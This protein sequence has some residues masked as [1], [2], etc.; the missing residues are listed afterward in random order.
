[1]RS[2]KPP[3][4]AAWLLEYLTPGDKHD[5]LVGDLLEE[6]QHRCSAAW[7]WRQVLHA[8][9]A[10]LFHEMCAHSVVRSVEFGLTWV[11]VDFV[12]F[13]LLPYLRAQLWVMAFEPHVR[14]LWR[15]VLN[16]VTDHFYPG[17]PWS[18]FARGVSLGT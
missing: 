3:T 18:G 9:P 2:S 7:F 8:I 14:I 17:E 5:A 6:F 4:L 10:S 11:W 15:F 1:M 13:H 16:P 12:M